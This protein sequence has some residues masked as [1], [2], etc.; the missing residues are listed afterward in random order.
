MNSNDY[1]FENKYN[2]IVNTIMAHINVLHTLRTGTKTAGQHNGKQ[3]LKENN[4]VILHK[5]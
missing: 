4:H 1:R 3:Y 5:V 2:S